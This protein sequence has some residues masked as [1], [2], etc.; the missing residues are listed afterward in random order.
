MPGPARA[1]AVIYAKDLARLTAFYQTVLDMTL[2]HS[3]ADH[4]VIESP[5]LQ[6]VIH[7]IPPQIADTITIESP[8]VPRDEQAI[9]LFFT[10]E[11]LAQARS[12][13]HAL[14][15]E[16]GDAGWAGPGFVA[17]NAHDPEG[18]I[19]QLRAPRTD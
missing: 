5:D 10:V 13:A 9:K 7:A 4:A 14:G 17:H 3:E 8:P 16:V 19:F 11:H 18:N 1:G 12:R 6:L 15:G 2:R